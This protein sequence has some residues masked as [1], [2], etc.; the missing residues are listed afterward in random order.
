MPDDR[1]ARRPRN[2]FGVGPLPSIRPEPVTSIN[3]EPLIPKLLYPGGWQGDVSQIGGATAPGVSITDPLEV[4]RAEAMR[5]MLAPPSPEWTPAGYRKANVQQFYLVNLT[6]AVLVL[7]QTAEKRVFL[8]IQ[9]A[10]SNTGNV[11]IFLD[12]TDPTSIFVSLSAGGNA[13]FDTFVPQNDIYLAPSVAG[14]YCFVT[15]ATDPSL[16]LN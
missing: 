1:T 5:G 4:K 8:Y 7:P 14:Q 13:L 16:P 12:N 6:P 10:F 15:F 3:G 2:P 9:T 11:W